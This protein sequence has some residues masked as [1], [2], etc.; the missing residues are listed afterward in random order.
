MIVYTPAANRKLSLFSTPFDN[1]LSADNRWVKM[2]S[3]V[4]WDDMAKV[5]LNSM[6]AVQGRPSVDL[7]I[8]LGV[9]MVK[10]VF[11]TN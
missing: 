6:S 8:V 9:L 11:R 10:C 4:P 3:L 2:E 5:F 1:H 7:R